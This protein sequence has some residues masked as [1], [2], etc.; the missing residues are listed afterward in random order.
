M[1]NLAMAL[2]QL[3][4]HNRD[5]AFATQ[6]NRRRGL[7]AIA[8]EL[9]AYGFKLPSAHSIKPKHIQKLVTGWQAA[10][11]STGTIKNR[12]GW[13][14]WWTAKVNK[15]SVIP[16]TNAELGL[17]LRQREG[18]NRA[19]TLTK[20][21]T[22]ADPRMQASLELMQHFG[23]RLEEALKL[24][25]SVADQGSTLVLK[26]S[27]TKGGRG[28]VVPIRTAEQR[29]LVDCIAELVG[30]GSLIPSDYSYIQWRKAIE[31]QLA[32]HGIKNVHGLRHHYAQER[33]LELV[34]QPCP[35]AGGKCHTEL[36]RADQARALAARRLISAE[37]GHAR[38]SITNIYLGK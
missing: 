20:A 6:A 2:V 29:A 15:S 21:K 1:N 24:R 16:R 33:Y 12:L 9:Y 37:L 7:V 22:M 13:L 3:T 35:L 36:N 26:P 30:S 34:G 31:A 28:R 23:L 14:R 38:L 32:K 19:H 11:L 17:P 5:G 18:T 4:K 8:N 25:V 27:W 10:G